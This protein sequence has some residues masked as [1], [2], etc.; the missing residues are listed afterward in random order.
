MMIKTNINT[1]LIFRTICQTRSTI[2]ICRGKKYSAKIKCF[3]L[4]DDQTE[5]CIPKKEKHENQKWTKTE[6]LDLMDKRRTVKQ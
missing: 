5:E 2:I 4:V 6:I 3:K 1:T